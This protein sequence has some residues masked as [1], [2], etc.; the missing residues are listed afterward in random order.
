[1]LFAKVRIADFYKNSGI[2]LFINVYITSSCLTQ[3]AKQK[4]VLLKLI[5]RTRFCI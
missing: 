3:L 5:K 2:Y 1:M 4:R